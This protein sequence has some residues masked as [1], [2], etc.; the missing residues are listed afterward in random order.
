VSQKNPPKRR[1]RRPTPETTPT[2][3]NGEGEQRRGGGIWALV[4]RRAQ[5]AA[6]SAQVGALPLLGHRSPQ[7][8]KHRICADQ[9]ER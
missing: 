4:E 5:G 9:G 1:R 6:R 3:A 8:V 2:P 7:A